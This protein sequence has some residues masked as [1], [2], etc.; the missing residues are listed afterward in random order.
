MKGCETFDKRNFLL[1]R[2]VEREKY[3]KIDL[4]YLSD[5]IICLHLTRSFQYHVDESSHRLIIY[6]GA[7]AFVFNSSKICCRC[8]T[9]YPGKVFTDERL[10]SLARYM[11]TRAYYKYC[12]K[13][14]RVMRVRCNKS[15][16]AVSYVTRRRTMQITRIS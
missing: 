16:L 15:N 4:L 14:Y 9:Q 5:E 7:L 13:R 3:C 10:L 11:R 6:P 8:I 1:E 12:T 2:R